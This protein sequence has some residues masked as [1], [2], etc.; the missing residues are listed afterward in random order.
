MNVCANWRRGALAV[1]LLSCFAGGPSWAHQQT[2]EHVVSVQEL[3]QAKAQAVESRQAKEGA[4]R[5]LFSSEKAQEALNAAGIDYRKVNRA[6]SQIGDEE[7][8]KLA[9][10]ARN[11][12]PDFS[13]GRS[14]LSDRDLLII[15]IIAVLLIAL[16]AVLK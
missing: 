1:L 5:Q 3:G 16:I 15:I 14:N 7:L 10:R 6:V 8:S 12:N 4:L 2:T 13:G 9:A 11:V